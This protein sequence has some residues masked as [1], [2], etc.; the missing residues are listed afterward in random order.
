MTNGFLENYKNNRKSKPAS[1]ME[2]DACN[3]LIRDF[4]VKSKKGDEKI[5]DPIE[6]YNTEELIPENQI[7]PGNI[8]TFIYSSEKPFEY[9]VDDKSILFED[10]L[11]VVLILKNNGGTISGI[12]LNMCP[13]DVKVMILNV[14]TNIDP[15]F[16]E[17]GIQEK[18]AKKQAPISTKIVQAFTKKD[19]QHDFIKFLQMIYPDA[20]YNVIFRTYS[21]GKIRNINRLEY[22]M[23]DSLPYLKY[24]G[25]IKQDVLGAIWKLS[26][27]GNI[28]IS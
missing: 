15:K 5:N 21:V 27:L 6:E 26:K 3:M 24:D 25:S 9:K 12:N 8:Y 14:V 22:Y 1:V 10:K 7:I 16:F 28:K 18:I 23:W 17:T 20:D 13:P 19:F 2:T 11:P 4:Y